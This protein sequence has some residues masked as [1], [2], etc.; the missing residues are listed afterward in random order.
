M[1]TCV[2]NDHVTAV[3]III[4]RLSYADCG[5]LAN[6][7]NGQVYYM[8]TTLNA[9]AVYKCQ[10]GYRLIGNQKRT[11]QNNFLWSGQAP[12]CKSISALSNNN[13]LHS[14]CSVACS[15][16][17]WKEVLLSSFAFN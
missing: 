12:S 8:Q 14:F 11:C 2:Y 10:R 9:I 13:V 3:S 5:R 6:P 17:V 16:N 7:T 1:Y 4:M 15:D